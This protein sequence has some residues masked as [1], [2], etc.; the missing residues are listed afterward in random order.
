MPKAQCPSC[1]NVVTYVAGYD[2]VCPKCGFR[3]AAP[4]PAPAP[5]AYSA[6]AARSPS[7]FSEVPAGPPQ[8]QGPSGLSIA[9]LACGIGGFLLFLTAPVAVILGI[10]ALKQDR[11]SASRTMAI[12][13]LVL[14][15]IVCVLGLLALLFFVA[16]VGALGSM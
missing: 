15:A 10:V 6:P 16:V 12:I 14:G 7:P 8:R 13:G 5:A 4:A 3:G 2:P 1:G 11:D 9:A